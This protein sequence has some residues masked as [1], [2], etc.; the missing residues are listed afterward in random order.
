MVLDLSGRLSSGESISS[1]RDE[2]RRSGGEGKGCLL[3]N[4][5]AV[6]YIDS[7]G[8]ESLIEIYNSVR[9]R[10]GEVRFLNP[11]RKVAELLGLTKLTAVFEIYVDEATAIASL[12]DSA[13]SSTD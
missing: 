10:H 1:F 12:K 9:S 3:I 13:G 4:L 7:L 11:A 6:P 5:E 8:L 2:A